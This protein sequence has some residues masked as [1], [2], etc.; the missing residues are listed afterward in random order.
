M[1][2]QREMPFHTTL[3]PPK[4]ATKR[5]ID[6]FG[7]YREAVIWCWENRMNSGAG[8]KADQAMCANQIG[9]HTPHMSR[10]VNKASQAPMNLNPDHLTGFEAFCGWRAAS[11]FIASQAQF[12]LLEQLIEERKTA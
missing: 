2:I 10:C 9:L 8:E 6:S 1:T 7:S 12:T 11:Q 5:V 3:T 4:F